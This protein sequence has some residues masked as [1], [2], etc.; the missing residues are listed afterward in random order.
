MDP[1]FEQHLPYWP[2]VQCSENSGIFFTSVLLLWKEHQ[3]RSPLIWHPIDNSFFCI[4]WNSIF[5]C[6]WIQYTRRCPDSSGSFLLQR[7]YGAPEKKQKN[8]ARHMHACTYTQV[9]HSILQKWARLAG[10]LAPGQPY[11]RS[12]WFPIYFIILC[13][14]I[15]PGNLYYR[16]YIFTRILPGSFYFL[17]YNLIISFW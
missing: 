12:A 4:A 6:L 9:L 14:I 5:Q 1:I 10:R 17:F 7:S 8:T 3:W 13:R 11:I 16:Y 15:L 2:N